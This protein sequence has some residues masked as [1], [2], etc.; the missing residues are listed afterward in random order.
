VK[1]DTR[2]EQIIDII[3]REFI[4]P[5][6]LDFDGLI[7]ENGEEILTSDNPLIRYSA[8]I[9][10]PQ[11]MRYNTD[12][13]DE[14]DSEVE[15]RNSDFEPDNNLSDNGSLSSQ[16]LLKE[17]EELINL[18]NSFKQSAISIT[19]AVYNNDK[20]SVQVVAGQYYPADPTSEKIK[21]KKVYRR[22]PVK[23][24]E[25]EAFLELPTNVK[26]LKK[27]SVN[28]NSSGKGLEF[29]ITFRYLNKQKNFS[30]Y[31]F[32][33]E[34]TEEID[35]ESQ[36][37]KE[38]DCFFQIEFT[39]N[40]IIGFCPMPENSYSDKDEDVLSNKLLYRNIKN[41]AIGHGCSADW[42]EQEDV[43]K[44]IKSTLIPSYEIK[45]IIPRNFSGL[46][47]KMLDMSDYGDFEKTL[48][49]L[50]DLCREYQKW[51]ADKET[52]AKGFS[53]E[54][55]EIAKK[56]LEECKHCCQRMTI[57]IDL[58]QK[59][60]IAKK[61]FMY[62]NRAML[63][64]QLHYR[65]PLQLWEADSENH[66]FLDKKTEKLPDIMDKTTWYDDDNQKYGEWYPFQIAFILINIESLLNPYSEDRA[67]VELIWFPTGGG[68]TEAYLGLSAFSIFLRKMLNKNDAGTIIIMRY[69]LRLLTA[70]QYDRASSMIC[71]CEVIRK[72]KENEL[73]KNRITI[74]LWVG[75]G[76]TPNKM[77]DGEGSAVKEFDKLYRGTITDNP[78][79][80]LKCP[81]CG[82]QMG[83]INTKNRVEHLKGY[84][85][86]VIGNKKNIVF[87][88][89]N[90]DCD[91]S[92][93]NFILPLLVV[94]EAIYENPP[95]LIIGTVDKFAMLPYWPEAQTI[96]G[97]RNGEQNAPPDL[98]IQDELHLISGPLGS[99][100]GHYETMINALCTRKTSEGILKPKI[101]A[102][103]ATISRAREQCHA[104]YDCGRD[105]VIQFPPSGIDAGES[106]FAYTNINAI[107]RIYAG[108]FAPAASSHATTNIRLYAAL[109]YAAKAIVVDTEIKRDPYW[110]NLGYYNS[111]RELGQAVTWISADITE[112]LHTIYKRRNE[113]LVENYKENRRY[114]Y[115]SEEL[116]SR[117]KNDKIAS[118]LMNL[119]IEYPQKDKDTPIDICLAT[120]MISVG[121]DIPRLGLMTVA[122]QPKTSSE[123][124][125]A[126]SR[127]GRTSK[128]PGL[129]FVVY[130]PGKP[131][132]RSH[133]EHFRS[134]H[135]KIYS[136]V[137]PTSVTPFSS[138]LRE[139]ALHAIIF[140]LVRLLGDKTTFNDPKQIPPP[141]EL[142]EIAEIIKN[143]V[144]DVDESE[145]D[146]TSK[147]I[148]LVLEKWKNQLP[149]KYHDFMAQDPVPLMYPAGKRPNINWEG[150]G[151]E[152]PM[153]MR[154]VD[155]PCEITVL[156]NGYINEE[157]DI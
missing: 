104:L 71:A 93:D 96:F 27:V 44:T 151:F 137:E 22:V 2:R 39:L 156:P 128:A 23:W 68:K 148:G 9:L 49:S 15:N 59:N 106:F 10:F 91:F 31:T 138:P 74:G 95:T 24:P 80:V 30:V 54:Y 58:L 13:D 38:T 53:S 119:A 88:C 67:K 6:P 50:R 132:D 36:S 122:G 47:L 90:Q 152:T 4:G 11:G 76:T 112:Y 62:M 89:D 8:G 100:V 65:L 19:A 81:W 113:D 42:I 66:V 149:Q 17:A 126:T 155:L 125:Q 14:N 32:T 82:A 29:C 61:A 101:V 102:S 21:A 72:E 83:V 18:S 144:H 37:P 64:Q 60:E 52:I 77:N 157:K 143:R 79:G 133:Y 16:E 12:D 134:Y 103:T 25:N 3:R 145:F 28:T 63:L 123:Y 85:K 5:D 129:I 1:E 46:S 51:I 55:S 97:I 135:S 87:Q 116:T 26:P 150:R 118:S 136:F 45:P 57:G 154:S 108:I 115:R 35:Y 109:L 110:T 117:I 7:Q 131:R 20:I 127:V 147:H 84:H 78:F 142:N 99:M 92:R 98:I 120:N 146:N 121:V 105:N 86:I 43:V 41:Y 130:N 153:S 111:L 56:H 141:D 73:G 124:I 94:D 75:S 48:E 34:N 139:R 140:G 33:L 107:G 69:T 70:Q 114:I 40:S